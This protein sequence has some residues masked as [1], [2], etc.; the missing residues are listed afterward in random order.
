VTAAKL[1]PMR[2]GAASVSDAASRPILC[3]RGI[4][5]QRKRR[6]TAAAQNKQ[7]LTEARCAFVAVLISVKG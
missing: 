3:R 6:R 2:G 5:I 7:K 4:L 1:N